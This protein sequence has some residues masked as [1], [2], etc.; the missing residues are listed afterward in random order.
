MYAIKP[1]AALALGGRDTESAEVLDIGW[2][3][4]PCPNQTRSV[5]TSRR[6]F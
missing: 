4:P 6:A 1:L 3:G 2:Y 5:G